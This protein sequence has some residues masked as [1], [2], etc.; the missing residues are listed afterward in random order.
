MKAS[1][2]PV[3]AS[4]TSTEASAKV[5]GSTRTEDSGEYCATPVTEVS[6]HASVDASTSS[7]EAS[8]EFST[9]SMEASTTFMEASLKASAISRKASVKMFKTEASVAPSVNVM[10]AYSTN[11]MEASVTSMDFQLFN[12][13]FFHFN[14][15]FFHGS[16]QFSMGPSIKF[17]RFFHFNKRFFHGSVQ[18]SMGP[19]IKFHEKNKSVQCPRLF[20]FEFGVMSAA[21]TPSSYPGLWRRRSKA[22]LSLYLQS[23]HENEASNKAIGRALGTG[24]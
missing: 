4:A 9:T 6:I 15:R 17:R 7:V 24:W 10:E 11:S 13:R 14:K 8:T 19:S 16:V 22:R 21:R 18:F 3:G 5:H 2:I 1:T 20:R 12:G 23:R